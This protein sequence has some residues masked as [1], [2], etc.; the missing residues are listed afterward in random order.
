M[1]GTG[2]FAN[3]RG[4]PFVL[5][6]K[7]FEQD[8]LAGFWRGLPPTLVGIIPARSIY[9]YTYQRTKVSL[10]RFMPEGSP[11]NAMTS[12][13]LAGMVGNTL[14]NPL[15]MLKTRMQLLADS[16]AGQRAYTG[17]RDA[18]RTILREE[19]IGG[20]YKGIEAS[21]WG[22]SEGAIQ[23]MLYE[24]VKSRLLRQ[25]NENRQKQGLVPTEELSK[26]TYFF[27]AAAAKMVAAVAVYPHEVSRTRMREQAR[28]GVFK[29]KGMWP[30]LRVIAREE[31]RAGLYSG[32]GMHLLK[33]VPNSALMFLTY[34][35]VRGWLSEFTVV[36]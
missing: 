35:V 11:G 24:Q 15:W 13:L 28:S 26:A 14:T 2:V 1:T 27:S 8:G 9:F 4:N 21:Y 16:A 18:I 29:Y 19:G 10:G 30:A 34:E 33:V 25:K 32:M 12:G 23:F 3:A 20:F 7:I 5:G 17:Y 31:G 22:C 6:A 36:D